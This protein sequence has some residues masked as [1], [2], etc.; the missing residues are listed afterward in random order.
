MI[1]STVPGQVPSPQTGPAQSI[2]PEILVQPISPAPPVPPA[3][4]VDYSVNNAVLPP[5][6]KTKR[7]IVGL[8]IILIIALVCLGSY[9][10][11]FI[12]KS[13][14]DQVNS[15]EKQE[16]KPTAERQFHPETLSTFT[17]EELQNLGV[18]TLPEGF[19][20]QEEYKG[21]KFTKSPQISFTPE[22]LSLI[23][24]FLDRTP[25]KLLT[26]G[27]A[28]V[29]TYGK[30]EVDTGPFGVSLGT[31]AF[32]S[33]NYLFFNEEAFKGGLGVVLADTSIDQAFN[34]FEHE[35]MHVTQFNEISKQ[36]T[37]EALLQL[38]EK[39]SSWMELVQNSNIIADFAA[40]AGWKKGPDPNELEKEIYLLE[41]KET[42]LTSEYGKT[43]IVEDMA[44]TVAGTILTRYEQF[45]PER[46]NWALRYLNETEESLKKGKFPSSSLYVAA[47]PLFARFDYTKEDE[48][49]A[50]YT[51]TDK[52]AFVSEK[53]NS[54]EEIKNYLSIE[55]AARG[56]AGTLTKEVKEDGIEIYKG[57]FLGNK[58]DMYLELR[59]YDNATGYSEKPTGTQ[60]IVI[61][62]YTF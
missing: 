52:Q 32:A 48:Y 57:D 28:A 21:V 23:H 34:A 12:K 29:V 27:P 9:F 62:G 44:E 33:G 39:E 45:S 24:R 13:K 55:L 17:K 58:R 61:S 54:L 42:A 2:P 20:V 47:Q 38:A 51:T 14:T 8:I 7:I 11:V 31:V 16:S 18:V 46:K 35:L 50:K 30:G 43:K 5:S 25:A 37:Q 59:S 49:K 56:W 26:P 22:Q 60:I 19:Q 6:K 36:L 41:N 1:D 40:I 3:Q 10:L 15:S 53:T 4:P